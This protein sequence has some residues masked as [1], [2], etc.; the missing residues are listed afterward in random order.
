MKAR[1]VFISDDAVTDLDAGK[2]F[3]DSKQEGIGEYFI[4]CLLSDI[5]SLKFFA[6][7]H[8]MC[9]GFFRMLSKRFP[10]AIYYETID[11]TVMIIAILDMR[12]NPTLLNEQIE[13]RKEKK[14]L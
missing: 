3:Y 4:D 9:Y 10:Y 1:E 6:G 8:G 5:E 11:S 13:G 12:R 7:I 14:N 2:A